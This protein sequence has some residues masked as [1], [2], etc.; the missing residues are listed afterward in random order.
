[1]LDTTFEDAFLRARAR[2]ELQRDWTTLS[3]V[4]L[5]EHQDMAA[6][7][8]FSTGEACASRFS[9]EL[10]SIAHGRA[11]CL[12]PYSDDCQCC[13]LP[14]QHLFHRGCLDSWFLTDSH[15]LACPLCRADLDGA[16]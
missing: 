7:K 10:V 1:L 16:Q 15:S 8:A 3:N 4:T 11:V 9:S 6:V 13:Q 5:L 14:C 12:E 2:G